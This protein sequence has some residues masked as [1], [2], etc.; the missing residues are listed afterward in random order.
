MKKV[1]SILA[2]RKED[3]GVVP[4]SPITEPLT[5]V[6]GNN[7]LKATM[8]PFDMLT[9]ESQKSVC[10]FLMGHEN[11]KRALIEGKSLTL[12]QEDGDGS[13]RIYGIKH[14]DYYKGES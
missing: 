1:K 2:F 9:E 10:D 14:P 12:I 11:M 4:T 7:E 3:G 5:G 8:V 6:L 13:L